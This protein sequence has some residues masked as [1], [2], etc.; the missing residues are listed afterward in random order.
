M[1]VYKGQ[2]KRLTRPRAT[3]RQAIFAGLS[4]G[5]GG[6]AT[7]TM[8]VFDTMEKPYSFRPSHARSASFAD[9]MPVAGC[10]G[11]GQKS[12]EAS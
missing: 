11:H 6:T 8:E 1:I 3:R 5:H 7:F 9:R 2:E 12:S 4:E 10:L